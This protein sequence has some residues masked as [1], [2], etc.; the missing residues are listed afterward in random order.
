MADG[1]TLRQARLFP[2]TQPH[3]HGP[4]GPRRA[5]EGD[6]VAVVGAAGPPLQLPLCQL[7]Q[8]WLRERQEVQRL[9]AP[10]PCP[11]PPTPPLPAQAERPTDGGGR[12]KILIARSNSHRPI[13]SGPSHQLGQ[14]GR[15]AFKLVNI[16]QGF[17][18]EPG[19]CSE[20]KQSRWGKGMKTSHPPNPPRGGGLGVDAPQE[21]AAGPQHP[22]GGVIHCNRSPLTGF[23]VV[24]R[25]TRGGGRPTCYYPR[26]NQGMLPRTPMDDA[27][28]NLVRVR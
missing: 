2:V 14:K 4:P 8:L 27:R 23:G 22:G 3:T 1:R 18:G 19:P 13:H 11:P 28:H 9:G 21:L 17:H 24:H 5:G 15:W 20:A 12:R 10:A 6:A 16:N 7:L 26:V 25:P